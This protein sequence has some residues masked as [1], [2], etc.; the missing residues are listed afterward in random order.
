MR[1]RVRAV[2]PA[3]FDCDPFQPFADFNQA[4]RAAESFSAEHRGYFC[5]VIDNESDGQPVYERDGDC[6]SLPRT[7]SERYPTDAGYAPRK[8][9]EPQS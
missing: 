9:K 4:W 1:Y 6:D 7:W 2:G 3:G 8:P 5:D